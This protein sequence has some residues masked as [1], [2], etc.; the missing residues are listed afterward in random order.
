MPAIENPELEAIRHLLSTADLTDLPVAR[1]LARVF[2]TVLDG[3]R[4]D[5][6][7]C[8]NGPS[9]GEYDF[10][11]HRCRPQCRG[12]AVAARLSEDPDYGVLL[13]EAGSADAEPK[14][15]ISFGFIQFQPD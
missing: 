13:L 3:A 9:C 5:G 15:S 2:S 11:S 8:G 7:W 1:E 6:Y 4:S 12:S 10:R 14:M